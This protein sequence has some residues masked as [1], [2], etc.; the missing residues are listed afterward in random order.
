MILSDCE[1]RRVGV[2]D[3]ESPTEG[4]QPDTGLKAD[5]WLA[6][7]AWKESWLNRAANSPATLYHYTDA[8]GLLGI[9]RSGE[10]WASHASF[11]NDVGELRYVDALLAEVVDSLSETF[12]GN[13]VSL[14]L[15]TI[16]EL[17]KA[18]ITDKFEL[19]L[20]CF[21]EDGD[22]LSQWRG[23][24]STGGGYAIGFDRKAV[25]GGRMLRR[26]IYDV[27]EQRSILDD[28]LR[29]ACVLLAN[30]DRDTTLSPDYVRDAAIMAGSAA[31][32]SIAECSWT[33]KHP[34]FAE[35]KEYRLLRA[36]PNDH[37][38]HRVVPELRASPLG[39]LPYTSLNFPSPTPDNGP[40]IKE[41]VVGPNQHPAQAL[42]AVRHLL[43]ANGYST[44]DTTIRR[45]GIP[46]RV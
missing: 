40:T 4:P 16:P 29:P 46:L 41:V 31:M 34:G 2:T 20:A 5:L 12:T 24:P 9:V 35:E 27:Q 6:D 42:Q 45:S 14:Y 36:S 19:Y 10:L 7:N 18:T 38:E 1:N 21:C 44:T 17:F 23:Y 11:V 28:I 43:D 8:A 33:F 3:S 30:A 37:Q 32:S 25:T 39:L 13:W 26:V 22:Q 15:D